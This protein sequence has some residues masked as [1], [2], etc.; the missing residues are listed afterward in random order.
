MAAEN[1]VTLASNIFSLLPQ[2]LELAQL[3]MYIFLVFFFGGIVVKGI[4]LRLNFFLKTLLVIA[5][6]AVCLLAGKAIALYLPFLGEG[7]FRLFQLDVFA[8]GI[9]TAF[10]LSLSLYLITAGLGKDELK[11]VKEQLAKLKG[12]LISSRVIKP[13]AEHQA[14]KMA[15][16][17]TGLKADSAEIK[18]DEWRVVVKEG[19]KE[20]LV[21]L[22]ALTAEVKSI[23]HKS[24]I[25]T[26]FSRKSRIAGVLLLIS[27][28]VFILLNFRGLPTITDSLSE[29]GLS[30][31]TLSGFSD[32]LKQ[33]QGLL[34]KS[35]CTEA[36]P[37]LQDQQA[38]S[39]AQVYSD[40]ATKSM[41]DEQSGSKVSVMRRVVKN[42]MELIFGFTENRKVCFT[43]NGSFCGCFDAGY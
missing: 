11:E 21:V 16:K 23:L 39:E 36:I 29:I 25:G 13:V 6:G 8:G 42:G 1:I 40:E 32:T 19:E 9:I 20:R 41:F 22:D 35:E 4:G 30:P 7:M 27:L 15:E 33:Q 24:K 28:L 5:A 37:V 38:L 12:L 14:L 18:G 10:L 3:A 43:S 34:D 2:I 26:F 31:E 17:A